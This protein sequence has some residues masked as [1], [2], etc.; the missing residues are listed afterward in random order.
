MLKA[1]DRITKFIRECIEEE[2]SYRKKREKVKESVKKALGDIISERK[3][4]KK[5]SETSKKDFVLKMLK[6]KKYKNSYL[7][8]SLWHPKNKAEKNTYR[9]LFSKKLSGKKDADGN[10]RA[11]TDDEIDS[12]YNLLKNK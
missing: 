2:I 5:K 12:L 9:S 10:K 7:A 4:D 11:F 1:K 3:K 8:Y 6:N